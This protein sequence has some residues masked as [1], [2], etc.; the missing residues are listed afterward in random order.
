MLAVHPLMLPNVSGA[1]RVRPARV[2]TSDEYEQ[3]FLAATPV[4]ATMMLARLASPRLPAS[5]LSTVA[6]HMRD[7]CFFHSL[8]QVECCDLVILRWS[9][10]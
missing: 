3:R 2:A 8:L 10:L 9:P 5:C 1:H 6:G 7:E 4:R